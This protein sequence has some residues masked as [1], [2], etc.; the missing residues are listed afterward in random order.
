MVSF[1]ASKTFKD[2]A[3]IIKLVNSDRCDQDE[4]DTRSLIL[5]H[6]R[7]AFE[8]RRAMIRAHASKCLHQL[9]KTIRN[10]PLFLLQG[11][12]DFL[13]RTLDH[14]G[15]LVSRRKYETRR[16]DVKQ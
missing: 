15:Y 7:T 13:A 10:L 12:T 3:D 2:L 11:P 5:P 9:R 1:L 14:F 6:L 16:L 4:P 8:Y